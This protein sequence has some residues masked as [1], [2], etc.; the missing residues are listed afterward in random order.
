[1]VGWTGG[2]Y[3]TIV[4]ERGQGICQLKFPAGPG[5]WPIFSNARDLPGRFTGGG[6]L[7]LELT[8]AS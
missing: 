4:E 5:I 3:L 6:Y 1:M 7:R 2:V 8:R